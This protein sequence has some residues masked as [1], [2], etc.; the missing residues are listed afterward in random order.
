MTNNKTDNKMAILRE[1]R[2]ANTLLLGALSDKL[3]KE[4]ETEKW[5]Q[6][7]Q[8]CQSLGAVPANKDYTYVRDT[9]WS[10]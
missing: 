2:D 10:N 9:F 5:K 7:L 1:I 4:N 6:T 8:E 3:T